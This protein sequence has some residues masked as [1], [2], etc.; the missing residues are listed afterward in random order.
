MSRGILSIYWG[1]ESKL[2]LARLK[3]SVQRFHPELKHE[4]I[5][6]DA[7]TGDLASLN[8]KASMFELSPFD[9]TLFLDIDTVVMGNL[10]FG[11]RKAAQFGL[12]MSICEAPWARR[13][14]RIFVGDEVEYNTGVVF[15]SRKAEPLFCEWKGLALTADTTLVGANDGK[16]YEVPVQ[17]Q[18]SFA[19]AVEKTGFHPFVLPLNWN[20][21]PLW[22]GSFFGPIK[23]WHDYADPPPFFD[24]LN[25]YY[26]KK[27][28]V[29]Q[30]HRG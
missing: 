26:S 17:D 29:I 21:R 16:V 7:P 3:A 28:S 14:P 5:K 18:G 30:F 10:D 22:H 23:V 11:F 12:A 25:T 15:F 13:Y 24:E 4:I 19:L 8:K 1:D 2:P 6:V 20:F 27:D 9:E